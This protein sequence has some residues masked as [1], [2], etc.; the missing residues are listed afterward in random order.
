[1]AI[2]RERKNDL[3]AQYTTLLES[4]RAVILA[5][6][7]GLS[8]SEMQALRGEVRKVDGRFH[9]T[10]NTLMQN[11][12]IATGYDLPSDILHGQLGSGFAL[13]ETPALAKV[14]VDFAKDRENFVIK[15]AILGNDFLSAAQVEN[16]AKLPSLDELRAQLSGLL[17]APARNM[18]A[19]LAAGVRQVANVLDALSKR[20]ESAEAGA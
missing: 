11:A 20:E 2:S 1:M 15:G 10:K 7:S 17:S 8:V 12:L 19:T 4:S 13:G 5:D 3:V 16:L 9:V 14:L 18:A 6:Y